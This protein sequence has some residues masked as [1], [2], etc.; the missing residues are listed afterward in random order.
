M[1][2]TTSHFQR[3]LTGLRKEVMQ[4]TSHLLKME[5]AHDLRYETFRCSFGNLFCLVEIG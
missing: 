2:E 4:K 1:L 5:I 3:I